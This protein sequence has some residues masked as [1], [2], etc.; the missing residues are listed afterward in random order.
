MPQLARI[1]STFFISLL[2][3][4][5][6]RPPFDEGFLLSN[7]VQ[8]V[9]LVDSDISL[10]AVSTTINCD[11]PFSAGAKAA[12]TAANTVYA[13]TGALS[14]GT[15]ALF[16][17]GGFD[18]TAGTFETF[19]LQRRNAANAAN[20]WEQ[21]VIMGTGNTGTLAISMTVTL[22]DQERIRILNKNLSVITSSQ[23][24]IWAQKLG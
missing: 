14:A 11:T 13:D 18:M 4:L 10:Q 20:I 8:P 19:L 9:S 16:I 22:L 2:N 1:T 5:G 23:L 21:Y 7:T 3:R 17:L 15:Y 6:I 12:G 24:S